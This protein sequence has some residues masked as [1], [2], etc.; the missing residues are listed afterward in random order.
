ML[1]QSTDAR[2]NGVTPSA[3]LRISW[4]SL[5]VLFI[6]LLLFFDPDVF[7]NPENENE[8]L[9]SMDIDH[10]VRI[11]GKKSDPSN[12]RPISLTCIA[13]KILEH[14]VHSHVMKHFDHYN[15]LSDC[16]HGFRSKRST[17]LQL[18]LTIHDIAS[19]LQ[20][21]KSIHAAVLDFSK[22]FDKV[23]HQRLL[24]KLEH[25][26][27]HGNLLSWMESFLTKRV[28]SVICEG[29]TSTSSPVTSGVPQ[30]SV[31][32][33]LLFLTYINDLPNGLTSTVKLFADDTLLYGVVVEDSD[34]D[35]LQDDLN[36]LEIW[37]NKWQMEFNPSK[38]N[39][40]CI[41]N[42]QSP[43]QRTYTFC[44]SKLEQVDSASYLGITVNSKLKWSEHISSISSKASRSLGLIKRNLWN[45]PRKVR[46]TAYTSIVRPKLEYASAS[47]DPH[48]KKDISTLERV[49]RKAAR[50]CLQNFN[51]TASVTDM[52]SDL[53]WDTLETRRKKN[54]LTLMY[55]LSH[56][57]V[58]IT[59]ENHLIPNSEKRT[60]NSHA[61]KYR[62][63]K[64][65]KDVFKFSFFPRSITEWNLLPADLV[66]CKSLSNFK[67]NLGKLVNK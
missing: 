33:P 23:P 58:D 15:I 50:F 10:P 54:R 57:L 38:C 17:E 22:A 34:C 48:H 7:Y 32:G 61:F 55:K 28:Q 16:Q 29:A 14:I 53:K 27:I 52:L 24:M 35:N 2:S 21:N 64:V 30:G 41:S 25:Y 43:H 42:K 44:G 40:I 51:K 39:I 31:L 62:M 26:G 4:T 66:N 36:K 3:R 60:H 37:Q 5:S 67:L 18:I 65:S 1:Y 12:Y 49:Q 9:A 59:T 20:Q 45:C 19:S 47:W 11:R 46:E 13:S 63:P 6:L 8:L 56:N